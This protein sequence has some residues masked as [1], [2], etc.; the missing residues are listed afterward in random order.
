[1]TGHVEQSQPILLDIAGFIVALRA[2]NLDVARRIRRRYADF[3]SSDASATQPHLTITLKSVPG[4]LFITPEPGPWVI[5]SSYQDNRLRF[6][7]YL[8]QG[9]VDLTS[10]QGWLEMNPEAEMENFLRV[11]YAWLCLRHGGLLL[12]AAGVVR[13]ECGYVFFG[14][15]G[16]GKT[17]TSRLAAH[18]GMVLSDDLVILRRHPLQGNYWLYGVPFKGEMSNEPRVN[19]QAPLKGIF[20]LRQNTSH[21]LAPLPRAAAVAE[22]VAASPFVVR[23][24]ALSQDLIAVC[25]QIAHSVSVQQLHFRRDDGF[26]KV[27][28]DYFA[29]LSPAA[30]PDG[31]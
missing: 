1:M 3:L 31:R 28:D 21:Y 12:H 16:A 20:R 18:Q 4:A 22:L 6:R 24:L 11:A 26:W 10:G 29:G 17:T 25:H 5:E 15:S 27:I 9:E 23:D 7:S 30:S 2:D 19:T 8:E 14:P 13:N